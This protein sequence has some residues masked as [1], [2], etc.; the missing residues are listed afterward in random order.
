MLRVGSKYKKIYLQ[1]FVMATNPVTFFI[2]INFPKAFQPPEAICLD[3]EKTKERFQC[4]I[5]EAGP[6]WQKAGKIPFQISR[7]PIA[8]TGKWIVFGKEYYEKTIYLT[9]ELKV[10]PI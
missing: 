1:D 6:K 9:N 5:G 4:E 7:Y 10:A 2:Q 3:N 8:S